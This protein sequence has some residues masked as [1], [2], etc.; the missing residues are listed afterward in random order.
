M[1]TIIVT[2]EDRVDEYRK[3]ETWSFNEPNLLI[4][5]Q[6]DQTKVFINLALV[7]YVEIRHED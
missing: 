2:Y 4:L 3:V 7:H 6:D 1:K 5:I